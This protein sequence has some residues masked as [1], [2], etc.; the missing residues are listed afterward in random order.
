LNLRF[1][2]WLPSSARKMEGHSLASR[3]IDRYASMDDLASMPFD[4]L[5][6]TVT[7]STVRPE[8]ILGDTARLSSR[9]RLRQF[10][11]ALE[12][13]FCDFPLPP[14]HHSRFPNLERGFWDFERSLPQ[15][16]LS[17]QP[18]Y[19][20]SPRDNVDYESL[21]QLEDVPRGLSPRRLASLKVERAPRLVDQECQVCKDHVERGTRIITLPCKHIYHEDCIRKWLSSAHTCPVCRHDLSV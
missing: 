15:L 20:R 21:H 1:R 12:S 6:R 5:V 11:D 18:L 9:P 4:Q 16:R 17:A 8:L 13:H 2:P 14:T 7:P 10:A 3:G 19:T